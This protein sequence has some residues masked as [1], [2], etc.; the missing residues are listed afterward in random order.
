ML[1]DS[2]FYGIMGDD[3]SS[4]YKNKL[5]T[6]EVGK[7][8]YEL[9]EEVMNQIVFP[10]IDEIL[11]PGVVLVPALFPG[12]GDIGVAGG[13][14]AAIASIINDANE[15]LGIDASISNREYAAALRFIVGIVSNASLVAKGAN[16]AASAIAG[17]SGV[18]LPAAVAILSLPT[19]NIAVA[20]T[21]YDVSDKYIEE[22]L[23]N[24]NSFGSELTKQVVLQSI[25]AL[26]SMGI[27]PNYGD[28]LSFL[29]DF[30]KW[31]VN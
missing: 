21:V 27:V 4:I 8:H 23:H 22:L 10:A 20:Y 1:D 25:K 2:K 26:Q 12:F 19:T 28:I 7:T 16:W 15:H 5:K 29:R 17:V 11:S 24:I 3:N 31:K 9:K 18:G 13:G 14:G 30:V 6:L